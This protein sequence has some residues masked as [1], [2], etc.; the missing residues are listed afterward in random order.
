MESLVARISLINIPYITNEI[1]FPTSI[2]V[3]KSDSFLQKNA[4]ILD[5]YLALLLSNSNCILLAETKAIST[6]EKK[7]EKNK[8]TITIINSETIL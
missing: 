3:I 6:P 4:I 8:E 2:V 5:E 1:L 7:A